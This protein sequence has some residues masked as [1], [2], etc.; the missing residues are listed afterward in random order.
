[1][2]ILV[3]DDEKKMGHLLKSI[4]E[5]EGH[6]CCITTSGEEGLKALEE[7]PFDV[8]LTDLKMEPV[9]GMEV[10]FQTRSRQP[11]AEVV[12]MTAFASVETA[13]AATRAGA[14]D[15]LCKPFK[16]E[17]LLHVLERIQERRRL[18]WELDHLRRDRDGDQVLGDS[19]AIRQVF[20]LVSQVAP[21]DATVL[22]RGESGTGKERI[23]RLIHA[24]SPRQA[25]PMIS[26]HCGALTE[27]LLE[28]ELFGHERGAFTGATQRKPGRFEMADGGTLFL[29][30]IGDISLSVQVKL[31]R[32]LQ[33]KR[34]ERVGGTETLSVNVRIIA[35]THRNLEQMMKEGSFR[36]DLFYRLSVFPIEIPP[37]RNR[38]EDIPLLAASFLARYGKGR[39]IL[40][41]RTEQALIQHS[42]PGNVREL[43]NLMERA[44]ILCEAGEIGLEHLPPNLS[45]GLSPV[46]DRSSFRIPEGGIVMED[47]EKS[48]ILQA[49][50]RS[51]GN[52]S[53]AAELLGLSR[54]QLYTRLEKYGLAEGEEA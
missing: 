36:E 32:V 15:F 14:Y 16:T 28:S 50:E 25:M 19:A 39:V 34:F 40:G 4:L 17:Q 52:K 44:T 10:L 13:L 3:V 26:V 49:L 20:R 2:D 51:H 12:V 29:D 23:A 47:L 53:Q 54:R 31:L 7:T 37:L 5:D 9:D 42:W 35:A 11:S 46:L 48:L 24:Q 41:K 33:E 6:A 8:V 21:T 43:E 22:L 1:M 18:R 27:T 30:E 45:Y 38:R